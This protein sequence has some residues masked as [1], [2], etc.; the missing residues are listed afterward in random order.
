MGV[1]KYFTEENKLQITNAIR[2]A[3]LN[4]SGEIR[5]HIEK[6]CKGDVLDQAA[7]VFEKLE[8]HKT[9]L[10]NGVLFYLAIEDHKFAILGDAGINRKVPSNFWEETKEIVLSKFKEG[11][12]TEGLASGIILAGEQL[13]EHF[14]Y[15]KNDLNELSDEISFGKN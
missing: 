8:L 10:R 3:E 4:T 7:Y 1:Q 9:N 6:F 5:I 11:K 15:Q 14:P 2:V 13:K 12:I